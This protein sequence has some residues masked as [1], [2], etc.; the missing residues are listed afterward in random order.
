V[1][2]YLLDT[3]A[4]LWWWVDS[5]KLGAAARRLIGEGAERICVS[6]ASIWEIA[7]KSHA[8]RLPE[9]PAF[10]AEYSGLM[11]DNGFDLITVSDQHALEA[12]YLDSPHRD[13]FDR[14]I[15]GQARCEGLVVVTR[16]PE[17]A[18]LGC[19]VLW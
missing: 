17:F 10:R 6:V 1:T 12:A 14:L 5:P 16:D 4:A 7:I 18:G 19:K 8:G 3:H 2:G 9:L 11:A 15:A 13:P